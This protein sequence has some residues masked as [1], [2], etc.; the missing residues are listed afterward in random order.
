[1]AGMNRLDHLE[2]AY[3][4]LGGVGAAEG[5]DEEECTVPWSSDR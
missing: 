3:K 2:E 4:V 1:M 5:G